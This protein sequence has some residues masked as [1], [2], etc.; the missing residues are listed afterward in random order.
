MH[1]PLTIPNSNTSPT[2]FSLA[3]PFKLRVLILAMTLCGLSTSYAQQ[4][5]SN[6]EAP[7]PKEDAVRLGTISITGQGE[8]LGAG[9]MLNEDTTKARSTVTRQST[10][11]DRATGTPYQALALLPGINTYSHDATGLFGG[12]LTMRGFN[13][14][15]IGFTINGVPV[16]DSGS[17]SVFPQEYVDQENTCTQSVAQGV[18][19]YESPHIGATGGTI[20]IVTC[21]PEDKRRVRLTQTLGG[22]NLSRTFVRYDSGR[23]ADGQAKT[24]ISASLSTAD[25]WKG[26]GR[27]RRAHVDTAFTW[28]LSEKAHILG[29]LLYNKAVNNNLLSMSVAQLNANGYNYDYSKGFTPGRLAAVAGSAQKET[30]PTPQYYRLSINPFENA[31]ASVSGSFRLAENTQLKVQPYYWYGYGTGGNQ[32][33]A[34]SETGFL[35]P[36]TGKVNAG[37]DLNS[38]GDTLDTVVVANSSVTRTQRPGVTSEINYSWNNHLLKFGLWY[39]HATHRQTG[40]ATYVDSS[41]A[42]LSEFLRSY[43][44]TRPDG[45]L[46]ES[47]DWKTISAASQ[48]YVADSMG[49]SD[50]QGLL[51]LGL[52]AP[53]IERD[54]TNYPSEGGNSQIGYNIKKSFSDVL[55]QIGVRYNLTK[56]HQVFANIGK[57]FRAPA[58]FAFA[59]NNNNVSIVNGVA[60]LVGDVK[61]ETSVVTDLGYRYQGTAFTGSAT[62]FDVKFK[63]RQ[64]N[65]YDPN[66]DRSIYTNT[67]DVKNHGL[68]LELGTIP[69]SGFSIYSSLTAQKSQIQ[70]DITVAKGQTLATSGKQFALTPESML[71]L[72]L[73]YSKDAI[74]GR[75]KAKHTGRQYAT[76]MNDEAVP[77]Y[78]T[79]DLDAG[80][81]LADTMS[82]KNIQFRFNV[83]NLTNEKFRNPN[84]GTVLNALPYGA[85]TAS[86]VFYYLGAPRLISLSVSA[87]F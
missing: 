54:F 59:P 66:L 35:N 71:G 76:L 61:A 44:I 81:K 26:E 17:Y 58:N 62:L 5:D 72:A 78:T 47:R 85:T 77:A 23:F 86:T 87:D 43:L 79:L 73:Q 34:Q 74:Y 14:D 65:A 12:G 24:F 70:N 80:Y 31:I 1:T 67:G 51:Q 48:V 37:R 11:K 68:E 45:S 56:E 38:D 39:E 29:S 52:R 63:N 2:G 15:Q 49:F 84:S 42:P 8:R 22:L 25:K 46:F 41:G 30:G 55:P 18:P 57:N 6:E 83:S 60:T 40:P 53:R 69:I 82:I 28:D 19:E 9:L 16:N 13:S 64:A 36:A 4:A 20:G 27:A 10:E 21:S 75:L 33:R 32:Q 3:N 50:E 7:R